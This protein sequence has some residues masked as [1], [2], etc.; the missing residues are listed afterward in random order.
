MSSS[1]LSQNLIQKVREHAPVILCLTNQV[2]MEFVANVLLAIGAAPIMSQA[3]EEIE[4]LIHISQAVYLNMG[5][6]NSAWIRQAEHAVLES[7]RCTK[8]LVFDPVG[9]GASQFRL[10]WAQH[11]SPHAQI[12]K[13]NASEICALNGIRHPS[14]G[15]ET[16]SEGEHAQSAARHLAW[17]HQQSVVMTGKN[18]WIHNGHQEAMLSLGS[19]MMTRVTGMGCALG[20]VLAAFHAVSNDAFQAAYEATH[21]FTQCGSMAKA[22]AHGPGS[23]RQVFLDILYQEK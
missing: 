10:Y 21:Y 5:T 2:T 7:Q 18:D 16:H 17:K 13:G 20:G 12:L 19:P 22:Q 14:R 1:P 8:P 6:L 11:F 9:A 3:E 15:V 4:E 23:F